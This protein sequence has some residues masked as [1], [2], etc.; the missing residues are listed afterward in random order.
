M[1]QFRTLAPTMLSPLFLT[2]ALPAGAEIGD[3]PLHHRLVFLGGSGLTVV[4]REFGKA[5][6]D[7]HERKAA[8]AIQH[9]GARRMRTERFDLVA[10]LLDNDRLVRCNAVAEGMGGDDHVSVWSSCLHVR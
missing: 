5:R 9:Q 1:N 8:V 6:T 10:A 2:I 3:A 7:D 4:D